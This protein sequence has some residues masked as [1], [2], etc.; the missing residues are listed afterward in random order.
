[1]YVAYADRKGII[2]FCH[3][4][5]AP[6]GTVVFAG[7]DSIDTLQE[8]VGEKAVLASDARTLRVPGIPETNVDSAAVAEALQGWHAS[9]F[10]NEVLHLSGAAS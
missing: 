9:S 8:R 4:A 7:D 1:M 2:G 5:Y 10:A 6:P 3:K